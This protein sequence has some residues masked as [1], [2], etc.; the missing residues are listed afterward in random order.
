MA[1]IPRNVWFSKYLQ[2]PDIN[3]WL[4]LSQFCL[5]TLSYYYVKSW[6]VHTASETILFLR[7][8]S[9][10]NSFRFPVFL[11]RKRH[12]LPRVLHF[13]L[14]RFSFCNLSYEKEVFSCVPILSALQPLWGSS[15]N[16]LSSPSNRTW[17]FLRALFLNSKEVFTRFNSHFTFAVYVLLKLF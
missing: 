1:K 17:I 6:L 12:T 5:L 11:H 4:W 9:Q 3:P 16:A 13:P 14:L 10:I 8:Q 2:I 15:C 7:Q